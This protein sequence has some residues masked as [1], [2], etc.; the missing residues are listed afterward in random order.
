M[1]SV[2]HTYQQICCRIAW[3]NNAQPVLQ[4][5]VS[6]VSV[7]DTA[8]AAATAPIANI[9]TILQF[10]ARPAT[11]SCHSPGVFSHVSEQAQ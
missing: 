3:H 1:R 10:Y 5:T 11:N 8:V 6:S 2:W 4:E 7:T 9:R